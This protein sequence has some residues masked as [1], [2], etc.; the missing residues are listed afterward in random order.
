M[1]S[2]KYK[3]QSTMMT[4]NTLKCAKSQ[5]VIAET[6]KMNE[7]KKICEKNFAK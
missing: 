1:M 7:R 2:E 4:R 5:P 6:A 3:R